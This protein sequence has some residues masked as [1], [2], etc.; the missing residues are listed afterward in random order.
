MPSLPGPP[1]ISG[2]Y[3]LEYRLGQGGMGAVYKARHT[4]LKTACAVKVIKL[5]SSDPTL[6][7]RFH[8]EAVV[9]AS[10]RHVN[11]VQV[12]DFG[13]AEGD[14]PFL[15]MEYIEGQSLADL[16]RDKGRFSPAETIEIMAPI[17]AGV[18]AAH[19]MGVVHRDLK[20]LNI[21]VQ[22]G[23]PL[24]QAVKVLDFG[25]AKIKSDDLMGSLA[26]AQTMGF[27]GSPLY[28]APELWSEEAPD[29]GADIY[30]MGVILFQLL[31]GHVPF[32]GESLPSVMRKHLME[33]PPSF[34]FL[35]LPIP[36]RIEKVAC[37]ALEKDPANRQATA[38]EFIAE[39]SAAVLATSQTPGD[40]IH[41]S[42]AD[43]MTA[44][45]PSQAP[46][47]RTA[48]TVYSVSLNEEELAEV[49]RSP[50]AEEDSVEAKQ[51][52]LE[53]E[54]ARERADQ[55][56][57]Q[58]T[59]AQGRADQARRLA[60]KESAR[61]RA[62][63]EANRLAREAHQAQDAAKEAQKRANDEAASR[64]Q[65]AAARQRA[66]GEVER[67]AGEIAKIQ[68][69]LD[70]ERLQAGAEAQRLAEQARKEALGLV[71]KKQQ[72]AEAF[73]HAEAEAARRMAI[74]ESAR[75]RAEV[76]AAR[77]AAEAREAQRLAQEG[78]KQAAVEAAKRAEAEAARLKAEQEVDRLGREV[79]DAQRRFEE[80]QL[81][82]L[83]AEAIEQSDPA[84]SAQSWR[85]AESQQTV[86]PMQ[87]SVP[88]GGFADSARIDPWTQPL[89]AGMSTQ[90]VEPTGMSLSG[91]RAVIDQLN[92]SLGF[93]EPKPR[94]RMPLI[95]A[96]L[97]VT[98]V[99][100][101]GGGFL[102]Y[103]FVFAAAKTNV[104]NP[105]PEKTPSR[106]AENTLVEIAGGT[107]MMGNSTVDPDSEFDWAQ[108]P[109]HSVRVE[110]F[111]I[112]KYEISM[113]EYSAFLHAQNAR[114]PKGWTSADPPAGQERFPVVNV[115]YS[116]AQE[117]AI[118]LSQKSGR[119]CQLPTEEQWEYAARSGANN[120]YYPWGNDWTDAAENVA[121]NG[122]RPVGS[123][124]KG[125][126]TGALEDMMGNVMEWTQSRPVEYQ[127][128]HFAVKK[129]ER[130][131]QVMRGGYFD[132]DA[133]DNK[134]LT[135]RQWLPDDSKKPS[136]GFR[137]VC[138]K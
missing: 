115:S 85:D 23:Q 46:G 31:T 111:L 25:L 10:I 6:N 3:Q 67:L 87:A 50:V 129:D 127:G 68:S 35:G 122:P 95:L 37:R 83:Q 74:E 92:A 134:L 11:I 101:A 13:I 131:Q 121:S 100:V 2:R 44:V 47:L 114:G 69:R 71:L 15:V 73:K 4:F 136:I 27:M 32:E 22:N 42:E 132:S 89:A 21:M 90:K 33:Q 105:S 58:L 54:E 65:E 130:A 110:S 81:R 41:L 120:Y 36:P 48:N 96:G 53:V 20:P 66:E 106:P 112:N 82:A 79:A 9:A 1:L 108:Y 123:F 70:Q 45:L 86:D 76:E 113:E 63:E 78:R 62:E 7:Q 125:T 40:R 59:E 128:A 124:K 38:E 60:E 126:A 24:H 99:A 43:G 84:S 75:Q 104:S 117:Y 107:F 109:A 39:L 14:N 8:Q 119:K 116:N 97:L 55:A 57:R 94:S 52:L 18:G 98:L 26:I 138:D 72:E 61:K 12:T 103:H 49:L 19:R 64:A 135:R 88:L 93:T 29:K 56:R 16:I 133:R 5:A 80:V 137:L 34:S 102:L 30:S 17:A 77:L 118:W 28:M 51:L 91:R